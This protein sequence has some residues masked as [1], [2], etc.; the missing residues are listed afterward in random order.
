MLIALLFACDT[1]VDPVTDEDLRTVIEHTPDPEQR[2]PLLETHVT[3]NPDSSNA[4]LWLARA[5]RE[6]NDPRAVEQYEEAIRLDKG[7][8]PRVELAYL[9][10]E[11]A[12]RRG[13]DPSK[14]DVAKAIGL[15]KEAVAAEPTCEYRHD[16][17]GLYETELDAGYV[18]DDAEAFVAESLTACAGEAAYVASWQATTG[19]IHRLHGDAAGAEDLLCKALVA[20]AKSAEECLALVLAR[21]GKDD[22]SYAPTDLAG[23]LAMAEHWRTR[24]DS[25]AGKQHLDAAAKIDAERTAAWVCANATA[26]PD[27]AAKASCPKPPEKAQLPR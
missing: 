4:H 7:A 9:L 5:Y 24:G 6:R 13:V 23:N 3:R 10:V 19:R 22:S 12:L 20:G 11:P 1:Q 26:W 17:V 21:T 16:L 27:A 8:I 2:L 14:E 18:D 25:A 15:A